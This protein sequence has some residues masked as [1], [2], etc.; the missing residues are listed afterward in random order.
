[1]EGKKDV[2]RL[3]KSEVEL[4]K[5]QLAAGIVVLQHAL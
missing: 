2:S 3:D 1:L 5:E 4:K